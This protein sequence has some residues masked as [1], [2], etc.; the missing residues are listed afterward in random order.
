MPSETPN[1]I[2][3][4]RS[5]VSGN[6]PDVSDLAL[7]EMALNT[8]DGN[9]FIAKTDTLGVSS[10]AT[11]LNSEQQPFI[12]NTSLSSI[13]TQFGGNTANQVFSSVLGGY[14]NDITGGGSSVING[15]DN[16]ISGDF[17]FIGSG[18]KNKIT[19]DGDYSF[20]AAGSGNQ[21]SHS[22]VFTLG[23]N[24]TSHSSDFTYVNNLSATG[25]IYANGIELTSSGSSSGEDTQVRSLTSNWESTYTTVSSNSATWSS[26]PVS[27]PLTFTFTGDGSTVAYTVAGTNNSTNASYIEVFVENVR[28]EPVNSYTLASD[29][30]TFEEP[31][32]DGTSILII[33][34]NIE[35]F[36]TGPEY[37]TYS[38][39]TLIKE[40]SANLEQA[41]V[42]INNLKNGN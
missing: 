34:P 7:G 40:L 12:L 36:N 3:I 31:P 27:N 19:E 24:L 25:K 13:S 2:L 37:S 11:F 15:E 20:I 17:S 29:V 9:V 4:K 32:D 22:N 38:L 28:Q 14:N 5:D 16:D 39:L 1:L 21:I 41:Y 18:Y 10:I 6:I 26:V 33:T 23:S 30:V 8:A 35:I 42:E